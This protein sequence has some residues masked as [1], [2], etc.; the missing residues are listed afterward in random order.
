MEAQED[1]SQRRQLVIRGHLFDT[2]LINKVNGPSWRWT[3][4]WTRLGSCHS[5]SRYNINAA[6]LTTLARSQLRMFKI[7]PRILSHAH[8]YEFTH[9]RMHQHTSI[10]AYIH[11]FIHA[12]SHTHS[13]AHTH[14]SCVSRLSICWRL[15]VSTFTSRTS[16]CSPTSALAARFPRACSS[17]SLPT[18][19]TTCARPSVCSSAVSPM[20]RPT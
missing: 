12:H 11:I 17:L 4:H 20:P 6:C 1:A 10:H 14:T 15:S 2:G 5:S 9:L 3:D 8:V 7:Y 19:R 18:A 13:H 16:T